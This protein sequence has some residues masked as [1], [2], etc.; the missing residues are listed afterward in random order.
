MNVIHEKL[1]RRSQRCFNLFVCQCCRRYLHT[2]NNI[3]VSTCEPPQQ[4]PTAIVRKEACFSGNV[5]ELR[6]WL[7]FRRNALV[8]ILKIPERLLGIMYN[9]SRTG[10]CP[11]ARFGRSGRIQEGSCWQLRGVE[12]CRPACAVM[13]SFQCW[14][15]INLTIEKSHQRLQFRRQLHGETFSCHLLRGQNIHF[16]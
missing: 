16:Y 14:Q 2:R 6:S 10:V 7:Q 13:W 12:C 15:K 9:A 5:I 1:E 8:A 11:Q 3:L 4:F